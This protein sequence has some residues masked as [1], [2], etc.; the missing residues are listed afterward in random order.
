MGRSGDGSPSDAGEDVPAGRHRAPVR[1]RLERLVGP[2][3]REDGG[4][5]VPVRAC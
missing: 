2:E 4:C 3:V 1:H 5:R